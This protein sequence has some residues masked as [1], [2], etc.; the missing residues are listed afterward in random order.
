MMISSTDSIISNQINYLFLC[1][2]IL[3]VVNEIVN[4]LTAELKVVSLAEIVYCVCN[5]STSFFTLLWSEKQTKSC[6]GNSASEECAK[7]T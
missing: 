7:V 2:C 3:D 5:F 1:S 4:F 6:S